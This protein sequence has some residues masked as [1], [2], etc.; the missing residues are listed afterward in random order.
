MIRKILSCLAFGTCHAFPS[1]A[2]AAASILSYGEPCR[3]DKF[4]LKATATKREEP[5]VPAFKLSRQQFAVLLNSLQRTHYPPARIFPKKAPPDFI[6]SGAHTFFRLF[7]GS[8]RT[9][10]LEQVP[11]KLVVNLV[12][13]LNLWRFHERAQR[14]RATVGRSSLQIRKARLDVCAK[15]FCGPAGFF[16]IF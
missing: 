13:I 10:S 7:H 14:S 3:R 6:P 9:S 12:M 16:E 15:Q 5:G 11:K 2:G 8:L 4:E 1:R